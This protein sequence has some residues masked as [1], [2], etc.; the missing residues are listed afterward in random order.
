MTLLEAQCTSQISEAKKF[1]RCLLYERHSLK[2]VIVNYLCWRCLF[3]REISCA[4][5]FFVIKRTLYWLSTTRTPKVVTILKMHFPFNTLW[6]APL[7]SGCVV[8]IKYL[9][10]LLSIN[11]NKSV[12]K[13]LWVYVG[14]TLF[15]YSFENF[16]W[17]FLGFK[18]NLCTHEWQYH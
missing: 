13:Y 4:N 17:K 5:K 12:F 9:G 6:C 7:L 14:C 1:L 3:D 2:S 16:F 8:M 10:Q 15:L 18:L 11:N